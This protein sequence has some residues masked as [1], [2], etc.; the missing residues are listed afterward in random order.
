MKRWV[1]VCKVINRIGD[2]QP[3]IQEY[4]SKISNSTNE[5]DLSS[6]ILDNF[7]ELLHER[8]HKKDMITQIWALNQNEKYQLVQETLDPLEQTLYSSLLGIRMLDQEIQSESAKEYL[9]TL[10]KE[11]EQRLYDLKKV[12]ITVYPICIEDLGAYGAIKS[13]YEVLKKGNDITVDIDFKGTLNRQP[14]KIGII[15]FRLTQN[16]IQIIDSLTN[17]PSLKVTFAEKAKEIVIT[18]E[19]EGLTKKLQQNSDYMLLNELLDSLGDGEFI[20]PNKNELHL[21]LSLKKN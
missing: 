18:F 1:V 8:N 7:E 14:H 20:L 13:L 6:K 21:I 3:L 9:T 19:A 11:I 16:L 4:R 10:K 17:I 5:S 15:A 2:I 12:S